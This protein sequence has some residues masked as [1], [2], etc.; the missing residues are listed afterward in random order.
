MLVDQAC[1]GAS[2]IPGIILSLIWMRITPWPLAC[3]MAA[4]ILTCVCSIAYHANFAINNEFNPNYLRL[5]LMGQQVG[6]C[7]NMYYSM[8][9]K[10]SS[11]MILPAACICLIADLNREKERNLAFFAS[12]VNI[13]LASC[14]SLSFIIQWLFAFSCWFIG[15]KYGL[16]SGHIA[17][18]LMCHTILHQYFKAIVSYH[19]L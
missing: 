19:G 3:A 6:L 5:D 8:L 14:F 13:L 17:W 2:M 12:G 18:H 16:N 4:Y 1:N 7:V 11:F 9:G 15:A 10:R